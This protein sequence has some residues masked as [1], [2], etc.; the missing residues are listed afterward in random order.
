MN[1]W[2]RESWKGIYQ[3]GEEGGDQKEDGFRISQF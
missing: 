1:V 2:K 3:E